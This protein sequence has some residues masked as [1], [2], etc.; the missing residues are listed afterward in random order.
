M[1]V[2]LLA[3]TLTT[4]PI[5]T[6]IITLVTLTASSLTILLILFPLAHHLRIIVSMDGGTRPLMLLTQYDFYFHPSSANNFIDVDSNYIFVLN[7]NYIALDVSSLST[8]LSSPTFLHND[9]E[10]DQNDMP[11]WAP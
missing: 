3:T 1:I 11:H 7:N 8:S 4:T 10:I 5:I 6:L 9:D 2:S